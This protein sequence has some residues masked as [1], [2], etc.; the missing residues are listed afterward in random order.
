MGYSIDKEIIN[1]AEEA[2]MFNIFHLMPEG[3]VMIMTELDLLLTLEQYKSLYAGS[4]VS[5]EKRKAVRN[6]ATRWTNCTVYYEIDSSLDTKETRDVIVQAMKEW[7][8]YTCLRFIENKTAQM[9]IQF[10]DGDGCYSMLGMQKK[11]Q[12]L[13]LAPGCRIKGI[14]IHEIGHAIG[15]I[16]EHMRPD[17]DDYIKVNFEVIPTK[18]RRNFLKYSNIAINT[19]NITYDY[20]SIMHYGS[21]YLTDSITTLDPDYQSKIGQRKGMTFKDIK[22]ANLMYNCSGIAGCPSKTCSMNGFVFYK[23]YRDQPCCTCWCDSGDPDNPLVPCSSRSTEVPPPRPTDVTPATK[24]LTCEDIRE[25]CK[26]M[27]RK[28]SEICMNKME[29]MM[30]L[31]AR[32]CN[33]CGKGKQMC[34]D[35]EKTCALVAASKD[36][37]RIPFM[38]ELCPASCGVCEPTNACEIQKEMM[39]PAIGRNAA[40]KPV[41]LSVWMFGF[42]T[43]VS[44]LSIRKNV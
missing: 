7:E 34:M 18:W 13:G 26:A 23:P 16:H 10:K 31:C 30:A 12:S 37:P 36:C 11:P 25:D 40:A 33:F 42:S 20:N 32:T 24:T 19:H 44:L 4:D 29:Q 2:D 15:W 17:R 41:L 5:R 39:G 3:E 43:A 27:K 28:D 35:Y 9:R 38:K 1:A 21:S 14:V 22:L 6:I 8:D